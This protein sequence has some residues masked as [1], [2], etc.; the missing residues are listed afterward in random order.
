MIVKSYEINNKTKYNIFLF[1]GE[2]DCL[3]KAL[4][5]KILNDEKNKIFRFE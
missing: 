5:K 3:K 1:Y 4:I 2:N